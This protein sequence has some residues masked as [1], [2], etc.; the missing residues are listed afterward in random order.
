MSVDPEQAP[1]PAGDGSAEPAATPQP[2]QHDWEQRYKDTQTWGQTAH[3]TLNDPDKLLAHLEANRDKFAD[4]FDFDDNQD[5]EPAG[6]PAGDGQEPPS[7]GQPVDDEALRQVLEALQGIDQRLQP[8]ESERM[9][10]QYEAD[11]TEELGD[12]K[13]TEGE[14]EVIKGLTKA[15]G[16]DRDALSKAVEQVLN[17]RESLTPKQRP[18]APHV[19]TD[20]AEDNPAGPTTPEEKTR[21]IMARLQA[22]SA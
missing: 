16:N 19:P 13:I 18:K 10:R 8:F 2:P 22:E 12:H 9:S 5:P 3:D 4:H 14:R 20:T 6:D 21:R 15:Y 1:A 11:L 17:V 7:N